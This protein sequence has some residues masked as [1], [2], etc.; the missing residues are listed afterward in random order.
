MAKAKSAPVTNLFGNAK[1]KETAAKK[2][3]DKKL[4]GA[5]ELGNKIK[6]FVDLKQSIESATGELKMV[7]GDIKVKGK[8]IFMEEYKRLKLTPETFKMADATGSTVAFI[9]A[10]RY[11][12]VDENKAQVLSK[13][14]GLLEEKTVWTMNAELVEKYGEAIS[15]F[16]MT[17]KKISD[18]DRPNLISGEKSFS[19]AKGSIDRLLTFDNPD[20][21]FELINPVCGLKR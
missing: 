20:M 16:I 3:V 2:T 12:L 4:I 5:T 17:S 9:V 7:E 19:V 14:N 1:V 21:I 18:E 10:D 6:R 8:Q 11:T 15:E 13:Y